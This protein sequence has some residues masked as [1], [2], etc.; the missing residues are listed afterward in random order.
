MLV[1][2]PAD[3]LMEEDL[4]LYIEPNQ[5]P[6]DKGR[7]HAY[8]R[9]MYLSQMRRNLAYAL[10]IVRKIMHNLGE[11][12]I[13]VVMRILRYL[14]FSPRKEILCTK[15]KDCQSMDACTDAN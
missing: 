2:Q 15:N 7:Y 13:K 8:G 4:K 3:T 5:V 6:V 1:C 14:K 12:H 10:S 11:L 9:L